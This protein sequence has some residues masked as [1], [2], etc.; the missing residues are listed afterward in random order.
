MPALLAWHEQN[1]VEITQSYSEWEHNK[2]AIKLNFQVKIGSEMGVR[3][4]LMLPM[5][6][7]M[8]TGQT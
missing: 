3:Y 5:Q 6:Q 4:H 7:C 2:F 8:V 1:F